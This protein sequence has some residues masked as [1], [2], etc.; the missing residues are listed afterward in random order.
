M[1][2]SALLSRKKFHVMLKINLNFL[3]LRLYSR[4]SRKVLEEAQEKM[5][6][7]AIIGLP[8][9]GKST[10]INTILETKVKKGNSKPTQLNH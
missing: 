4:T 6:K 10:L 3:P 8:N 2:V 7:V 1:L 9:S 5:V